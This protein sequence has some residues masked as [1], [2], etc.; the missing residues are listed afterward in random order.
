MGHANG[1][2]TAPVNTDDISATLGVASH[3]VATLCTSD[4]IN[5]WSKYKPIRGGDYHT[6]PGEGFKG[7]AAD[8]ADGIIY[9]LKCAT[10]SGM[11]TD[12]HECDFSYVCKP[13]D[14]D[15]KRMDDFLGVLGYD[16]RAA[17][18]P[19]A[20]VSMWV[21]VD[22]GSAVVP[23][24]FSFANGI[25]GTGKPSNLRAVSVDDIIKAT[26]R[27][28]STARLSAY[29]PCAC[30]MLRGTNWLRC[31][32]SGPNAEIERPG[33]SG[34]IVPGGKSGQT[35]TSDGTDSGS[36][37][38]NWDLPLASL[39]KKAGVTSPNNKESVTVSICFLPQ[40]VFPGTGLNLT[41]WVALRENVLY[42]TRA[43]GC[44]GGVGRRLEL[45][46]YYLPGLR[47]L[48]PLYDGKE[49]TVH[50]VRASQ[51]SKATYCVDVYLK[52]PRPLDPDTPLEYHH[53]SYEHTF[54]EAGESG[55]ESSGS[56]FVSLTVL[57]LVNSFNG[58]AEGT[59]AMEWTVTIKGGSGI[60]TNKG[61]DMLIVGDGPGWKPIS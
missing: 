56:I 21:Y 57:T 17:P 19:M 60:V 51:W 7:T 30:V 2:I 43:F 23:I 46:R 39:L 41:D 50:V 37:L 28:S 13:G 55:G 61:A 59:W 20:G 44:P 26:D 31:L 1:I 22:V 48:S 24:T 45:R 54:D 14:G 27:S 33:T 36:W 18:V 29:Y 15:W 47:C 9:G 42:Y 58:I 8:I 6:L 32:D 3:D 4:R 35:L 53:A 11:L 12:I 40:V 25:N 34:T 16:H 52:P 10:R 49:V 5:R 38:A